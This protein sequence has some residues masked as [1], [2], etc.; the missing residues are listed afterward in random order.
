MLRCFCLDFLWNGAMLLRVGRTAANRVGQGR[1]P[2]FLTVTMTRINEYETGSREKA[3]WSVVVVYEDSAGREQAV[4][5]C[6]QLVQRFLARFEFDVSWWSFG[7][8]QKDAVAMEAAAKAA[9][10]DLVI[11]SSVQREDFPTPVRRWLE[12]WRDRRGEREGI[13]AG[14][15]GQELVGKWEAAKHYYLRQV[16]HRAAMDYLTQVPQNISR[17]IPESLESYSERAAQVTSVLDEILHQQ[18]MP[19]ALA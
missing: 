10:A 16:A 5:F 1:I 17:G 3:A 7:L 18:T 4:D 9:Q 8:L 15:L 2:F 11:I 14:V 19:P 6:D 12:S 13:L